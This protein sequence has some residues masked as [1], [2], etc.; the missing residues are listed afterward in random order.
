MQG[1]IATAGHPAPNG[2]GFDLVLLAHVGTALLAM[3][4]FV[5]LGVGAHR[6][7]DSSSKGPS[8]SLRGLFRP[9][10]DWAGRVVHAVP[11]FGFVLLALSGGAFDLSKPWVDVG[12]ALYLGV[13]GVCEG[14]VFPAERA[15]KAALHGDGDR[16][17]ALDDAAT[18]LERALALA[19]VLMV[20]AMVVMF[21]QF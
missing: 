8:S 2:V 11:V 17:A 4:V 16:R 3:G 18:S 12:A 1:L 10:T 20:A 7:R 15:V 6:V 5:T 21:V 13:A 9:G 19:W 14:L